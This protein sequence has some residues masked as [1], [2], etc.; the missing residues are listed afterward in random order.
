LNPSNIK[1]WTVDGTTNSFLSMSLLGGSGTSTN[2]END[3]IYV[4]VASSQGNNKDILAVITPGIPNQ[5]SLTNSGDITV[6]QGGS[7]SSIITKTLIS[8]SPTSTLSATGLPTGATASFTNGACSPNCTSQLTINA[9][10]T[11]A[12]GSY[13]IIISG[14]GGIVT[15]LY[16]IVNM[17]TPFTYT[18]SNPSSLLALTKNGPAVNFTVTVTMAVG[19]IPQIVTLSPPKPKNNINASPVTCTPSGLPPYTCSVTISYSA[20]NGSSGTYTNQLISGNPNGT[21]GTP[22]TIIVN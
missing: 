20:T 5:Y 10:S 14:D 7:G 8:G 21:V 6:T 15:T 2:C 22:F 12:I 18:I 4:A 17:Q 13:P 3:R 1:P 9:S 16:L 19:A 11:V